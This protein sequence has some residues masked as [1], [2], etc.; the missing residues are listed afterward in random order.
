[1]IDF[2]RDYGCSSFHEII[3]LVA[4]EECVGIPWSVHGKLCSLADW[5]IL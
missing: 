2:V 4:K 1:M 5:S 3:S